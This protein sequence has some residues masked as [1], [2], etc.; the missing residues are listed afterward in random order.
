MLIEQILSNAQ[1]F[2]KINI[3]ELIKFYQIKNY[4]RDIDFCLGKFIIDIIQNNN[5][6][7]YLS[8]FKITPNIYNKERRY[9]AY[10]NYTIQAAKQNDINQAKAYNLA[11]KFNHT[12]VLGDNL[13]HNLIKKINIPCGNIYFLNENQFSN[14][15]LV[16]KKIENKYKVCKYFIIM[17]EKYIMK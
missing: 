3:A 1:L 7:N 17:N 14:F 9:I 12:I 8:Q 2:D 13:F 6:E 5:C 10:L 11:I 16:P 4:L 15:F